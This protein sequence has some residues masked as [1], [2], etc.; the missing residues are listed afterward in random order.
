MYPYSEPEI[1]NDKKNSVLVL[2]ESELSLETMKL[3]KILR[4]VIIC[5]SMTVGIEENKRNSE[6]DPSEVIMP[7]SLLPYEDAWKY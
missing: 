1:Y 4:E 3:L 7:F 2:T 5:L 6:R